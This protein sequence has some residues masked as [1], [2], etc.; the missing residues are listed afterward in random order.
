MGSRK[1]FA[2]GFLILVEISAIICGDV[3]PVLICGGD[4]ADRLEPANPLIKTSQ[5]EFTEILANKVGG[6]RSPMVVF[7][8]ENFCVEDITRNK[9]QL[10]GLG[11]CDYLSAVEAPL[12]SLEDLDGYNVSREEKPET[13]EDGQAVI[14]SISELSTVPE[15]YR[16]LVANNPN[17]IAILTGVS[18]SY[19]RLERTRRAVTA[20]NDTDAILFYA[21]RILFYSP[22]GIYAKTGSNDY[23]L[24]GTPSNTSTVEN[25]TTQIRL[26]MVFDTVTL[27]IQFTKKWAG[28]WYFEHVIYENDTATETLT[29]DSAIYFPTGFSY[30]CSLKSVFY[31]NT[32]YVNITDIQVQ[33]D[34]TL[35]NNNSTVVFSDGYDCVGF[36]TIPIWSGIFVTAIMALIMIWGLTMILDIRTMDRFDDPKGKTI[37]VGSAE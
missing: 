8:Q 36:T 28:Y 30:H 33:I 7:E 31:S 37:T 21:D 15:L 6:S 2:L 17:L 29:S 12:S 27:R 16:N 4:A 20:R 24:L 25:G 3:A 10:S 32:T 5:T 22:S 19:N 35:S 9:H 11:L 1:M 13:I 18:C 26:D 23:S 14:V 34:P